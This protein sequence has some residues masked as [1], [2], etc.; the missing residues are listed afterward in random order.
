MSKRQK[1]GKTRVGKR[2]AK[3]ISVD[4]IPLKAAEKTFRTSNPCPNCGEPM[5]KDRNG[6]TC[7]KC[8]NPY[9]NG[10]PNGSF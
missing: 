8:G 4:Y 3:K 7:K 6:M 2:K 1:L 10:V 5:T 9:G